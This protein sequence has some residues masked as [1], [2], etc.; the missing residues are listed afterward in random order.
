[1]IVEILDRVNV[2]MVFFNSDCNYYMEVSY[3]L[4]Y[5]FI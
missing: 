5:L 4:Y 1:M 3:I 2:F